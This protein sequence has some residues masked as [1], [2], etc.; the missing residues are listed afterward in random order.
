M[1]LN[2]Q[3]AVDLKKALISKDELEVSVLRMTVS[4]I[5]NKEISLRQ[6]EKVELTDEQI[7]EVLKSEIKKRQDSVASY[8]DAGRN[9][10]ADKEASEIK[11][12]E[13]Y[14]PEQMSD[15][16]LEKIISELVSQ[17]DE[18]NFGKLMGQAMGQVK[19]CADGNRVSAILKKI[20]A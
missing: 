19:G 3:I 11:I 5:R 2:E 9:D 7:Q 17:T 10:L 4:A 14:L 12:L 20:L 1:N 15:D 16:E 6:G 18:K 8:R 13:K